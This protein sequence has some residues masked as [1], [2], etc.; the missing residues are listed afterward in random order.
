MKDG[1]GEFGESPI[2]LRHLWMNPGSKILWPHLLI[3]DST[4]KNCLWDLQT[5][6][7]FQKSQRDLFCIF[8]IALPLIKMKRKQNKFQRHTLKRSS[9]ISTKAIKTTIFMR[10]FKVLKPL[11]IKQ[12]QLN[13]IKNKVII[14]L[15]K[16]LMLPVFMFSQNDKSFFFVRLLLSIKLR[17]KWMFSWPFS[18]LI[19]HKD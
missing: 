19:F 16:L 9:K 14:H 8:S 10:Q 12:Q 5:P 18:G 1:E 4:T 7:F 6:N 2:I 15:R 17:K 13:H 11:N 3:K